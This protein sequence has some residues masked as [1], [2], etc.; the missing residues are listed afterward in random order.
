MA[1]DE[2]ER[3]K[4]ELL[5]EFF[6]L[7]FND[8]TLY[9]EAVEKKLKKFTKKYGYDQH[10]S[11]AL[12]VDKMFLML[13]S[14]KYFDEAAEVVAPIVERLLNKD[15]WDNLDVTFAH[16]VVSSTKTYEQSIEL[17][18]RIFKY[19][20]I[21]E[22]I[23]LA[24]LFN[25]SYRILKAKFTENVNFEILAK[26]FN[27]YVDQGLQLAE[28][29]NDTFINVA[30]PKIFLMR[31]SLFEEENE[32][33]EMHLE[34]LKSDDITFFQLRDEFEEIVS[35]QKTFE[36]KPSSTEIVQTERFGNNIRKLRKE[37][38]LNLEDLAKH[39]GMTVSH[40]SK[41]ERGMIKTV[42]IRLVYLFAETFNV[43]IN[44]LFYGTKIEDETG[45]LLKMKNQLD[46]LINDFSEEELQVIVSTADALK[47]ALK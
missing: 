21:L 12:K 22:N 45:N 31:K 8:S 32:K 36:V 5:T 33:A 41:Y 9:R 13:N 20:G 35:Y 1:L 15:I 29:N 44:A 42:S 25:A 3:I 10:I 16:V 34:G 40:L 24:T 30:Y 6:S 28:Q 18:N 7:K 46:F 19:E 47:K 2:Q 17:V 27:N 23:K 37:R 4:R 11:D 26:I 14:A 38:G 43:P 39:V